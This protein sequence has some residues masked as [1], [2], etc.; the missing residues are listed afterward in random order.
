MLAMVA[1]QPA[2]A[3][4]SSDPTV[5][6]AKHELNHAK[7]RIRAQQHKMR[8]L[9]HGLN[10]LAT[11]ISKARST[12]GRTTVRIRKTL[13]EVRKLEAK[14]AVLK[15]RLDQRSREAYIL[16]PGAPMLYLLTAS[17]PID[18]VTR[19][20]YLDEMNRRDATLAAQVQTVSLVLSYR[21]N[22]LLRFRYLQKAAA[23]RLRVDRK[24]LKRKFA[25][26][27]RLMVT[28]QIAKTQALANLSAVRPFAVC[29]VRGPHAVANDFGIWVHKPKKWG[30]DHI[31]QG[32]D[33]TAALGTPIVAPFDGTA[34][35][36]TNH[37]GGQAVKVYGQFGYVYN[38]HLSGFGQLGPVTK[39]TV[40]GYVG[41]TGDAG[42][43]HDHFEWHPG[44][45]PAVD[46]YPFLMLV[47]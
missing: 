27:Q 45:G 24:A 22:D 30:G 12:I 44:N 13:V 26:A 7:E 36:A 29:P 5:Q 37:I 43:P 4:S 6:H 32:N 40:I 18:A 14:L 10:R 35:V 11:A 23:Q 46:P 19:I 28:L 1:A 8:D 31:H 25:Q 16:G 9:Q 15:E 34:V 41:A 17:S 2:L 47:C 3:H 20:S 38:A 39:G 33:I 42:G 21:E